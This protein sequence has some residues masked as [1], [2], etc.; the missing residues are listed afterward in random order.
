MNKLILVIMSLI[1]I[2]SACSGRDL[3]NVKTSLYGH[4]IDEESETQ[5]Y[6]SADSIIQVNEEGQKDKTYK[7]L[8]YDEVMNMIRIREKDEEGNSF[9]TEIVFNDDK[10]ESAQILLDLSTLEFANEDI[11]S[12]MLG[13]V[14]MLQQKIIQANAKSF[15]YRWE[16][17]DDKQEP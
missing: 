11:D 13:T 16:Y 9:V 12:D 5:Y 10:R 15:E 17:V 14:E 4:W 1:F 2:L 7:V 6:I 8:D 3:S